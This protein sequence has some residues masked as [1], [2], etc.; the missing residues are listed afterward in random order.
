[1]PMSYLEQPSSPPIQIACIL[2]GPPEKSQLLWKLPWPIK[3]ED[4]FLWLPQLPSHVWCLTHKPQ[5]VL[6]LFHVNVPCLSNYMV[7][8]CKGKCLSPST[9]LYPAGNPQIGDSGFWKERNQDQ[10]AGNL[11]FSLQWP[12]A[13]YLCRP[14]QDES[15]CKMNALDQDTSSLLRF[16][17]EPT[18]RGFLIK[19]VQT[20]LESH[21]SLFSNPF[22]PAPGLSNRR[23]SFQIRP[24][25]LSRSL[26]HFCNKL[27][28][29][30]DEWPQC[31][32]HRFSWL[33][34]FFKADSVYLA[35]TSYL[36]P[37]GFLLFSLP[38]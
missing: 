30:C 4:I 2:H 34:Y 7:P 31:G 38:L 18:L 13:L 9:P 6:L 10:K 8:R 12:S 27:Q 29:N 5:I 16:L 15:I 32:F 35:K 1:M 3:I 22:G 25:S 26:N 28:F 36:A 11:D 21:F 23:R 33:N 20:F 37:K 19:K 14:E 17:P 24:L